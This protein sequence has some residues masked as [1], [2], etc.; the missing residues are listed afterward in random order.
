MR[1]SQ[2]ILELIGKRGEKGLPLVSITWQLISLDEVK[3]R[4]KKLND[5]ILE[6]Q[7][8]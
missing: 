5:A 3:E 6:S 7:M 1:T 2:T 4:R 8:H